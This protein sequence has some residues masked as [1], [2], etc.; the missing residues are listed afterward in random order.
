MKRLLRSLSVLVFL[1]A[2]GVAAGF[3][4][5]ISF[6]SA[7]KTVSILQVPGLTEYCKIDPASHSVLPSGRYVTPV[8]KTIRITRAPFGMTLSPDQ[9][10]AL[11]LHHTGVLTVVDLQQPDKAVRV[12]SYD[13]K[14]PSIN[15]TTFIG[16]AFAPDNKTV[17]LSGGDGGNIVVFDTETLRKKDS[18]SINGLFNGIDYSDSYT[19]DVA[20]DA[21]HGLLYALD[22][23]NNRMVRIELASRRVTGSVNVGR[24]PFGITLSPDAKMAFVANVGLYNY[25]MV[26]G[27]TP[28]NKDSMLLQ[29]P[30][31][32]HPTPESEKGVIL[33][34]GRFIPG[35]GSALAEEAMSV[36]TI[37]LDRMEVM[38]RFKTGH[39]IGEVIEE[40][41][42][43]G[44]ASPNSIAVGSRYAF[45][46]N[47][48]NDLIT[49]IDYRSHKVV[50]EIKLKLDRRVD[51]YRGLMPFGLCL[52]PDEKTL[53]VALLGLNAVA[54]VDVNKQKVKGYI[55]A[56]WGTTRVLCSKDG[57][58]LYIT[59]ARGL[60]AGPNGGK[61]FKAPPQ[62]TYIG[63]IQ[64][65]TFQ[66]VDVPDAATLKTWT[67]Q[68]IDNTFR[69][70]TLTDDGKN[71]LP[72]ARG[73]RHSPI[74]HILYI[75]KENRTYDEMLG[76][77]PGGLRDESLARFG[78]NVTIAPD[79]TGG[80]TLHNAD[81]SPNHL[82]IA[83]Q[84][85]FSDNFYCDSDASIH[86]HHWMI[87]HIPNEYVEAN[88]AANGRFDPASKAPGRRFPKATGAVDPEDYNEIGGLWEN[89][90]RNGIDFFNFGEANEYSGVQEDWSD[91]EFGA[92]QS[93]VFPMPKAV[94]N[95][96][97]RT[98]AGYNT[99]IPD[100][101]RM[102]QFEQEFT[103]RWLQ[104][105]DTMPALVALQLPNDH[106]SEPRPADGYPYRH[107]YVA[108][109]DMALGRILNFLSRTPYW[110]ST[111]VIVTE[112]DPQG[113][114]DHIDAHRSVLLMAGP[115]VK[116]GYISH[117][118]ANFGSLLRVIYT[119]LDLPLVNQY[120]QTASLLDDFFTPIP[121]YTPYEA[122]EADVRVYDAKKSLQ[123][124]GKNFDW[125][126]IKQGPSMDDEAEQR[127]DHY[128]QKN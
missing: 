111:L 64:L 58:K 4:L 7:Q 75:T 103:Q 51:D 50:S 116:R 1:R 128:R 94:Y 115:Y 93:V 107:A 114:V 85:A 112:D 56:G 38:D 102:D 19:S 13:N 73:L 11:I 67:Q 17:Y 74:K 68:V 2:I 34:D 37:D 3:V 44:G 43:V 25:P 30:P 53:Y 27:L 61:D 71:P 35:L 10:R 39:Q 24:I 95:R 72:P 41:E 5:P 26:P 28:A 125:R 105:K 52:S 8:G 14:I 124:Y 33:P 106:T 81:V 117:R 12:P 40:V 87:G 48:T 20:L 109:N 59:S 79:K 99:N 97:S 62:G 101:F 92:A 63:D 121:D 76:Q 96:T 23:G 60:G 78:V 31:Y 108:D 15:S 113:G 120:D 49:V 45:V 84:W 57:R 91:T 66:I 22:R 21:T 18:I 119:V 90:A 54:V 65:G 55:P 16:A 29:F 88:S 110:K 80:D 47:A 86:G 9:K 104:G 82:K 100:Q 118:H 126:K 83:K 89:L 36:W 32:G 70:V 98:Y 42:I 123:K 6:L 46:S 77:L 127:K 69:T 122:E